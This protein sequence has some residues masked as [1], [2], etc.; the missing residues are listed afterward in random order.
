MTLL[1]G[2]YSTYFEY[3]DKII[4]KK[5]SGKCAKTTLGV[6]VLSVQPGYVR[7]LILINLHWLF[8]CET[9]CS[10]LPH[11]TYI[12]FSYLQKQTSKACVSAIGLCMHS[13]NILSWIHAFGSISLISEPTAYLLFPHTAL[14]QASIP[15]SFYTS[16]SPPILINL[17]EYEG[18]MRT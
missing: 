18:G 11:F 15:H 9:A 3:H 4:K 1:C 8:H 7:R 13:G 6:H 10:D 14:F 2:I 5:V 12:S 17:P 16:I